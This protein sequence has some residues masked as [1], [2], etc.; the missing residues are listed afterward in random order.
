ML[1]RSEAERRRS[2]CDMSQSRRGERRTA[3]LLALGA[4]AGLGLAA[5]GLLSSAPPDPEA[6]PEGAVARVNE[7]LIPG[8]DFERLVAGLES[9]SKGPIDEADRRHVLDRM[10]DEELLVQRALDLG[11]ARLDR[12]VRADLTSALIA[13]IVADSEDREPSADELLD[14]YEENRDFFRLPGRLRVRQIFFRV[15]APGEAAAARE[16][17][18]R[19][20]SRL[21]EGEP[22]SAV[23]ADLGDEEISP[24]PD[25]LLPPTKLREYLGPT[26]LRSVLGLSAG[27]LS[28]PVRSGVG[29]HLIQ[30]VER[31]EP[32]TPSFEAALPQLRSEWRR[33]Q[34]DLALRRYLDDLRDQALVVTRPDLDGEE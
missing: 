19:A 31:E 27:E 25:A 2:A 32:R 10:I 30:L 29:V 22:W 15:G 33:R 20:R 9:D 13:S 11:L 18:E 14:F 17:A 34:G 28:Q 6:L 23:R 1:G 24:V 4:A 16:R 5:T 3:I 12:R 8:E 21:L 26:A 7:V